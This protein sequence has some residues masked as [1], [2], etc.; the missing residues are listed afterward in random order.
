M[1]GLSLLGACGSVTPRPPPENE[2]QGEREV[3]VYAYGGQELEGLYCAI[4]AVLESE[5]CAWAPVLELPLDPP[6]RLERRDHPRVLLD[7]S[8]V[9]VHGY[10]PPRGA[11]APVLVVEHDGQ[12]S[13]WTS[14]LDAAASDWQVLPEAAPRL[15][16][17]R[18]EVTV[19]GPARGVGTLTKG[20]HRTPAVLVTMDGEER[21]VDVMAYSSPIPY[22]VLD[23]DGDGALEVTYLGDDDGGGFVEV[24]ELV[25][26]FTVRR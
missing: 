7:D 16:V 19:Y 25:G 26:E 24:R 4:G 2:V 8:V 1:L 11:D 3:R 13:V 15:A 10:G 12:L 23:L 17:D 5:R 21:A 22:A 14:P 18:A 6:V 9:E 20:G